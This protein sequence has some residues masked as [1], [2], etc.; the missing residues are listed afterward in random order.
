MLN[1]FVYHPFSN[2]WKGSFCP[3]C[4][5]STINLFCNQRT[6]PRLHFFVEVEK[7][8][9]PSSC[10]GTP[11][12]NRSFLFILFVLSYANYSPCMHICWDKRNQLAL[13]SEGGIRIFKDLHTELVIQLTQSFGT[14]TSARFVFSSFS[15]FLFSD[16]LPFVCP[17]GLTTGTS[18]LPMSLG[19]F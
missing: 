10:Q 14:V 19:I 11:L 15:A 17:A 1:I 8:L 6:D 3:G 13:D 7:K 9:P 16:F 12:I 2:S 18:T 4:A 5:A